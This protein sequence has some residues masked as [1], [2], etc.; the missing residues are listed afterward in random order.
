[1]IDLF[2]SALSGCQNTFSI[3]REVFNSA[4]EVTLSIVRELKGQFL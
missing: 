4:E 1:M 2:T 3:L